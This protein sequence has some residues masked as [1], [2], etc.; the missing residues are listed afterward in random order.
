MR[1]RVLTARVAVL[2]GVGAIVSLAC[3]SSE[4]AMPPATP[5]PETATTAPESTPAATAAAATPTPSPTATAAPAVRM[6][7]EDEAALAAELAAIALAPVIEEFGEGAE[8]LTAH[9][10]PLGLRDGEG[11]LWAVVTNG[12]QPFLREGDGNVINFFHFVALYRR[13]ADASWSEELS[14]ITLETAPQRTHLV[15][16]LDP[17]PRRAAGPGALIAIRGQT[18]AHAGTFD[19][20]LAEGEV[21]R[22]VVS[23]ISAGPDSGSIADLDGDGVAELIFNTSNPY[24]FCYACAVEERSEQVYRWTGLEYESVPL[25]APDD[26][27]GDLAARAE[28]AVRLAEANLWRDAAALATETSRLAPDHEGLRWLSTLVNRTAVL[29]LAYAGSP[30]QPLLTNVLAGEYGAAYALMQALPPEEAFALDGPLISGTAAETDLPAMVSYL[31][32]YADEALKVRDDD[33]AIHAVRALG[34][35]LA[36]PDDLTRARSSIGRAL[37]LSPDDAFLQQARAYLQS[38][39]VAPGLPPE[40]PDPKTLLDAPDP[41]FFEEYTLGTGDRGRSV[42]ALHQRL[43]RVPSLGFRYPGRYYDVYDEATREAVLKLQVEAGLPPTGVVDG[44]TWEALEDAVAAS[45]PSQGE[46]PSTAPPIRDAHGAR[47]GGGAGRVSHL[48]RRAPPHLD[49][50]G[51][52]RAGAAR[53]NGD[54]LRAGPERAR[55]P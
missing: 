13:N 30:G 8:D 27:E 10:F 35:V 1:V 28:R 31:L 45:A 54:V 37:R 20:L 36:S 9:A 32:F 42:R 17:G 19:V 41:S 25:E 26:L 38:I 12:P 46:A 24:V 55:L 34:Q 40:A 50:A 52:G 33:P 4:P 23:H 6:P 21:L 47:P 16:V 44:P 49:A 11:A 7:D 3:G 29:R 5:P 53:R 15:E 43:A 51:A 2:L 22:T 48:R 14:Q 18:G 39:E